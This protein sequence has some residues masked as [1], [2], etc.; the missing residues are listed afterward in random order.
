LWG[1][2][3]PVLRP[4]RLSRRMVMTHLPWLVQL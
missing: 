4:A 1:L 2:E 3:S